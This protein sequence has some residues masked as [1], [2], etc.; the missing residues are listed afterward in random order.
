M[1]RTIYACLHCRI[2]MNPGRRGTKHECNCGRKMKRMT[3]TAFDKHLAA[4]KIKLDL[5]TRWPDATFAVTI[6]GDDNV[7]VK[8]VSGNN[9][10][11][12][13]PTHE[14]AAEEMAKVIR[15]T[16]PTFDWVD[17]TTRE[18]KIERR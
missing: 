18:G 16:I 3:Y 12:D 1:S 13:F 4:Q 11:D 8:F 10:A 14:Q 15:K 7:S 6:S 2:H 17:Y 9:H 5:E